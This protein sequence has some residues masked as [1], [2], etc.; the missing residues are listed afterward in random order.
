MQNTRCTS[1]DRDSYKFLDVVLVLW[2]TVRRDSAGL[3][4]SCVRRESARACLLRAIF[5]FA[6]KRDRLACE[7]VLV[8]GC[9]DVLLVI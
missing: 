9:L 3:I 2:F 4:G 1:G 5:G 6:L 8:R 7:C